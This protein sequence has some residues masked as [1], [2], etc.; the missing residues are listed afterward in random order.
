MCWKWFKNL[1]GGSTVNPPTWEHA[2]K[3]ALSFGINNYPGGQNDLNGCINDV[4]LVVERLPEFQIRKFKDEEVT[5]GNTVNQIEYVIGNAVEN[6]IILIHYSGHGTYVEDKNGDEIDGYDEAL[7]LYDGVL[8]DDKM[9]E[10]LQKIPA[11]V[12]V[13]LLLDSCFSG[14]ATRNPHKIRFMP[15]T[16]ERKEHLRIKRGWYEDMKWIVISGCGENQTSADA[17]INGKYNG[18]FTYFAMFTLNRTMTY[19]TW[20]NKIR[21]F[22]PSRDFD[23]APTLEGN[24][25]LIN[26]QVLI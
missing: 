9:N 4:E 3:V 11:G 7:Y 25:D 21:E 16:F 22:L 13:A 1:F 24:S 26:K 12:T 8:T 2:P 17:L 15:P 23:Q 19:Q 18:A 10:M 20:F 6:D 5:V 14:T